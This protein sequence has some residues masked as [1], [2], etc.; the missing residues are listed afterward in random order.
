MSEEGVPWVLEKYCS[1][2]SGDMISTFIPPSSIL[3][4]PPYLGFD[5]EGGRSSELETDSRWSMSLVWAES[6]E[7]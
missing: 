3:I 2:S 7:I 1:V 6:F 5:E 4:S